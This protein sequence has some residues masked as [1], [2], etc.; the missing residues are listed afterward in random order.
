M[1][2]HSELVMPAAVSSSRSEGGEGVGDG[3]KVEVE[4][5]SKKSITAEC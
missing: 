4:E 2:G 1:A 5:M 3:G